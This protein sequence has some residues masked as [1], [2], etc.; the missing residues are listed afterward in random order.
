M[1]LLWLTDYWFILYFLFSGGVWLAWYAV[2]F[3]FRE[4]E[5]PRVLTILMAPLR[6]LTDSTFLR[7]IAFLSLLVATIALVSDLT[8]ALNGY[9]PWRISAFGEHWQ[10]LAPGTLKGVETAVSESMGHGIWSIVMAIPT[11]VFLGLLTVGFAAFGRWR[12]WPVAVVLGLMTLIV[13][14]SDLT[15][16]PQEESAILQDDG[17]SRLTTLGKHLI[18]LFSERVDQAEAA[19]AE[20]I[21]RGGWTIVESVLSIPTFFLFGLLASV[22]AYFGRE[23][24]QLEIFTN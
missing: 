3:L 17:P 19:F 16:I 4:I 8:P 21:G 7:F 20:W 11:A 5:R 22:V 23:R 24:T 2:Y 13:L 14:A 18:Y 15:A 6:V 1:E 10:N 12:T 9:G